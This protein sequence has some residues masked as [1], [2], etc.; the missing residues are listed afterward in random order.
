M[1][2]SLKMSK[3][4]VFEGLDFAGKTTQLQLAEKFFK[5][6][7]IPVFKTKAPGGTIIGN[8]IRSI[9]LRN[10]GLKLDPVSQLL[11]FTASINEVIQGHIIPSLKNGSYVLLDRFFYSTCAYQ[12]KDVIG[13]DPK[14]I[15]DSVIP[16][17]VL[18]NTLVLFFSLTYET[19]KKR[20]EFEG[21]R[22]D[23]D[24]VTKEEFMARKEMYEKMIDDKWT[25]IDAGKDMETVQQKV[26]LFLKKITE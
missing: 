22:N 3:V 7:Y 16:Q 23:M 11:L 10:D 17:T 8:E 19:Y 9:L 1:L 25:V 20:S 5:E 13:I 2:R 6:R 14:L 18:D 26:K 4:V 15:L 12:R 24:I 21:I